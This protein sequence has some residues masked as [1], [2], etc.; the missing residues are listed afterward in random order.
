M[1]SFYYKPDKN[2]G[3][4]IIQRTEE[5]IELNAKENILYLNGLFKT[6]F[7]IEYIYLINEETKFKY[8]DQNY[9]N[10]IVT[11]FYDSAQNNDKKI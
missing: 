3:K 8:Q 4:L 2:N 10:N 11:R 6:E 7:K 1:I 5:T 9:L